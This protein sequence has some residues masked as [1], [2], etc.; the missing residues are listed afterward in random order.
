LTD[1]QT[2]RS[3][4]EKLAEILASYGGDFEMYWSARIARVLANND[5]Q[6]RTLLISNDLWG[7]AGSIA[8][9]AGLDERLNVRKDV[10]AALVELGEEQIDAGIVNVRTEFWVRGKKKILE[11]L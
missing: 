9:Q 6:V 1:V 8:D 4:L 7:G 10:E 2:F 3:K 11:K 5:D